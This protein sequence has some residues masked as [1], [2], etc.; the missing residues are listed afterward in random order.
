MSKEHKLSEADNMRS[1][2]DEQLSKTMHYET[3][4]QVFSQQGNSEGVSSVLERVKK[5]NVHINVDAQGIEGKSAL[6]YAVERAI[7]KKSA[8]CDPIIELLLQE[9]AD[10]YVADGAGRSPIE[11]AIGLAKAGDIALLKKFN[12]LF[13]RD[14]GVLSNNKRLN[15]EASGSRPRKK[16]GAETYTLEKEKNGE[17]LVD[18]K[19]AKG[20]IKKHR[21]G[22]SRHLKKLS[23][24]VFDSER[25]TIIVTA[26]GGEKYTLIPKVDG[27][28]THYYIALSDNQ[29]DFDEIMTAAALSDQDKQMIHER[30]GNLGYPKWA[31]ALG[32]MI[33][34]QFLRFQESDK[35]A[36]IDREIDDKIK[37]MYLDKTL[38]EPK[39]YEYQ[40][41]EEIADTR[42]KLDKLK[43]DSNFQGQVDHCLKLWQEWIEKQLPELKEAAKIQLEAFRP[44]LFDDTNTNF[45]ADHRNLMY[46]AGK[47]SIEIITVALDN[48]LLVNF[49]KAR[50]T[51]LFKGEGELLVCA[52]GCT[53]NLAHIADGIKSAG[54]FFPNQLARDFVKRLVEGAARNPDETGRILSNEILW[55]LFHSQTLYKAS[56]VDS[57]VTWEAVRKVIEEEVKL[58]LLE[59]EGTEDQR[60]ENLAIKQ[61]LTSK[62]PELL[63]VVAAAAVL[64]VKE[65]TAKIERIIAEGSSISIEILVK[66]VVRKAVTAVADTAVINM[67]NGNLES[68]IN[69]FVNKLQ[70]A[71]HTSVQAVTQRSISEIRT[72]FQQE[73]IPG[74]QIHGIAYLENKAADYLGLTFLSREDI[75]QEPYDRTI[76]S[77]PIAIGARS[78]R[79]AILNEFFRSILSAITANNVAEFIS[80]K[81]QAE[82]DIHEQTRLKIEKEIVKAEEDGLKD[83]VSRLKDEL[84]AAERRLTLELQNRLDQLGVDKN[85]NSY[86][87]FDVDD[88]DGK[89][90][91]SDYDAAK[92]TIAE[93]L[94]NSG[95]FG[96][97]INK[98]NRLA[99]LDSPFARRNP[100]VLSDDQFLVKFLAKLT[101]P[102]YRIVPSD[103]GLTWVDVPIMGVPERH[104][105]L[106]LLKEE[107]GIEELKQAIEKLE[108]IETLDL[109]IQNR[110]DLTQCLDATDGV[111]LLKPLFSLPFT[112]DSVLFRILSTGETSSSQRLIS[113]IDYFN[114]LTDKQAEYIIRAYPEFLMVSWEEFIG[115]LR[116][117]NKKEFIDELKKANSHSSSRFF[118]ELLRFLAK[119]RKIEEVDNLLEDFSKNRIAFDINAQGLHG[120]TALHYAV[121]NADPF[122]MVELLL[123]KGADPSVL[124]YDNDNKRPF[125]GK[126]EFM[127][128]DRKE[129]TRLAEIQLRVYAKHK[130]IGYI[131]YLLNHFDKKNIN[132]NINAQGLDG[133]TALYYAVENM[134]KKNEAEAPILNL[135][136]EKGADPRADGV[137]DLLKGQKAEWSG[138]LRARLEAAAA[139]KSRRGPL[140]RASEHLSSNGCQ[141]G[142]SGGRSKRAVDC[143]L[144]GDETG[145]EVDFDQFDQSRIDKKQLKEYQEQL[146]DERKEGWEK[147][148]KGTTTLVKAIEIVQHMAQSVSCLVA[149]DQ[150]GD[151][152]SKEMGEIIVLSET[153]STLLRVYPNHIVLV[154]LDSELQNHP[155]KFIANAKSQKLLSEIRSEAVAWNQNHANK[156][157]LE[158]F[159]TITSQ[160][161]QRIE[162][163]SKWVFRLRHQQSLLHTP[164]QYLD[165][166][167]RLDSSLYAGKEK[168]LSPAFKDLVAKK[169]WAALKCLTQAD[170]EA[171]QLTETAERPETRQKIQQIVRQITAVNQANNY[172]QEI[173]EK[174]LPILKERVDLSSQEV[175]ALEECLKIDQLVYASALVENPVLR[176]IL[177]NTPE[178]LLQDQTLLH[179]L[180]RK[181][182]KNLGNE[183]LAKKPLFQVSKQL[184]KQITRNNKRNGK[185]E[186]LVQEAYMAPKVFLAVSARLRLSAIMQDQGLALGISEETQQQ[187]HRGSVRAIQAMLSTHKQHIETQH[188]GDQH[189]ASRSVEALKARIKRLRMESSAISR[190]RLKELETYLNDEEKAEVLARESEAYQREL[191]TIPRSQLLRVKGK[192]SIRVKDTQGRLNTLMSW[193][194]ADIRNPKHYV[195]RTTSQGEFLSLDFRTQEGRVYPITQRLDT[196]KG[197]IHWYLQVNGYQVDLNTIVASLPKKERR[198]VRLHLRKIKQ[199]ITLLAGKQYLEAVGEKALQAEQVLIQERHAL[200]RQ[201]D[202]SKRSEV[203]EILDKLMSDERFDQLLPYDEGITRLEAELKKANIPYDSRK[204]EAA[205]ATGKS[206]GKLGIMRGASLLL[207]SYGLSSSD[208]SIFR[209]ASRLDLLDICVVAGFLDDMNDLREGLRFS[210]K[211]AMRIINNRAISGGVA[212]VLAKDIEDRFN[213]LAEGKGDILDI[214]FITSNSVKLLGMGFSYTSTAI[215]LAARYGIALPAKLASAGAAA[216]LFINMG[217]KF[218]S[219]A[220]FLFSVIDT[221]I[222]TGIEID[223]YVTYI[224]HLEKTFPLSDYEKYEL[225]I[226]NIV[227]L[228]VLTFRSNIF[229]EIRRVFGIKVPIK[230]GEEYTA[231]GSKDYTLA[232]QVRP[233]VDQ[234]KE[235]MAYQLRT[236]SDLAAVVSYADVIQLEY[237]NTVTVEN[238]KLVPKQEP[239]Q[240]GEPGD[241]P[242]R[243]YSYSC[244]YERRYTSFS[245][246]PYLD[247]EEDDGTL[248]RLAERYEKRTKSPPPHYHTTFDGEK[249][250]VLEGYA[251]GRAKHVPVLSRKEYE[252]EGIRMV[253]IPK[254]PVDYSQECDP[255]SPPDAADLTVTYPDKRQ[256]TGRTIVCSELLGGERTC[257]DEF[258]GAKFS[259]NE[260]V[261]YQCAV[262]TKLVKYTEEQEHDEKGFLIDYV[263]NKASSSP[264]ILAVHGR[265]HTATTVMYLSA[266]NRYWAMPSYSAVMKVPARPGIEWWGSEQHDTVFRIEAVSGFS[267]GAVLHPGKQG[268][269]NAIVMIANDMGS[270]RVVLPQQD[271]TDLE[272]FEGRIEGTGRDTTAYTWYISVKGGPVARFISTSQAKQ[273]ITTACSTRYVDT[274]PHATTGKNVI[275]T[276]NSNSCKENDREVRRVNREDEHWRSHKETLLIV[277]PDCI[278]ATIRMQFDSKSSIAEVRKRTVDILRLEEAVDGRQLRIRQTGGSDSGAAYHIERVVRGRT[279]PV[280]TIDNFTQLVFVLH[281]NPS[282]IPGVCGTVFIRKKTWDER[283]EDSLYQLNN[284]SDPTLNSDLVAT[285]KAI[286]CEDPPLY[287]T[288]NNLTH[289]AQTIADN[290]PFGIPLTHVQLDQQDPQTGS[291]HRQVIITGQYSTSVDINF[292]SQEPSAEYAAP[293]IQVSAK[294]F[295]ATVYSLQPLS[296]ELYKRVSA[297]GNQPL[298]ILKHY[299]PSDIIDLTA[300]NVT[301]ITLTKQYP[302]VQSISPYLKIDLQLP[303]HSQLGTPR[304]RA[305]V[306]LQLEDFF[307]DPERQA[308]RFKNKMEV[309]RV[310]TTTLTLEAIDPLKEA[311]E[312]ITRLRSL[313]SLDDENRKP[314]VMMYQ[315]VS[316]RNEENKKPPSPLV[317]EKKRRN[318]PPRELENSNGQPPSVTSAA[319]QSTFFLIDAINTA[320]GMIKAGIDSF[321]SF[322]PSKADDDDDGVTVETEYDEG[323]EYVAD[324]ISDTGKDTLP[325]Q[326]SAERLGQEANKAADFI[327]TPES[328]Q[329]EEGVWS[330][331]GNFFETAY[332]SVLSPYVSQVDG[333]GSLLLLHLLQYY[334]TGKPNPVLAAKGIGIIEDSRLSNVL[335]GVA[336]GEIVTEFEERIRLCAQ[337]AGISYSNI[338]VESTALIQKL[339]KVLIN[340]SIVELSAILKVTIQGSEKFS[341]EHKKKFNAYL[342][343]EIDVIQDL[344]F[345]PA[346]PKSTST[347]SSRRKDSGKKVANDQCLGQKQAAAG[348]ISHLLPKNRFAGTLWNNSNQFFLGNT[349][350][351]SVQPVS[352]RN[353]LNG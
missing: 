236:Y 89:I 246:E 132:Y 232:G 185:I 214:Y 215:K 156:R 196:M 256:I 31:I 176:K 120:R 207:S 110:N 226:D 206:K 47:R 97:D 212:Y 218:L 349:T 82:M 39:Y 195:L 240:K 7:E 38:G 85:Y 307:S 56:L 205:K 166:L 319:T 315:N 2:A 159:I 291:P 213:K 18:T 237:T 50:M 328:T 293:S 96:I 94:L 106:K 290:S 137:M 326:E 123:L 333:N 258:K 281:L 20:K 305:R 136:L 283:T 203:S 114:L 346:V 60:P 9:G 67:P 142:G 324:P 108:T 306:D 1:D 189:T 242:R 225:V 52:D 190:L 330:M 320:K 253:S 117:V 43:A 277:S 233:L 140:K 243:V 126:E 341:E 78:S 65:T 73:T 202:E 128:A 104:L 335:A 45:Y 33:S 209:R 4:L 69:A 245:F 26:A 344:F 63:Q 173:N 244:P 80:M 294:E 338:K 83:E 44:L 230:R 32:P 171:M 8:E 74:N 289:L 162:Q 15:G 144:L 168:K 322:W 183:Y 101:G 66:E 169:T 61:V 340:K 125:D 194:T 111:K 145:I 192:L 298:L 337:S 124:I 177:E 284:I 187:I 310:N 55:L 109:L 79:D 280:V 311:S 161:T 182:R 165:Q 180:H 309:S 285:M 321:S 23:N 262:E 122:H 295:G 46:G 266:P 91:K 77:L 296:V 133:K 317:K 16:R 119:Y 193:R 201:V 72:T 197:K 75:F 267:D 302:D 181:L 343:K 98:G 164:Q 351:T 308:I 250:Y 249:V 19:D 27:P 345:G 179:S 49:L 103:I 221:A 139:A 303:N 222:T 92:L 37:K 12:A 29:I 48:P 5:E 42:K 301:G 331:L 257:E 313:S 121:E 24:Y 204:V 276:R 115:K 71:I 228:R 264:Y 318:R 53:T 14:E 68:D 234:L 118:E 157:S 336:A 30:V 211:G 334:I 352:G 148:K 251:K 155:E 223:A 163:E 154:L 167:V 90:I 261:E 10:P 279:E 135:L 41:N 238:R 248:Y 268:E 21:I 241:W 231:K 146:K 332:S 273:Y 210:G 175:K 239:L 271:D 314:P 348:G 54:N 229:D 278:N 147:E 353:Q 191:L 28:T 327:A 57:A 247:Q 292:N 312:L 22:D 134:V 100:Q 59:V 342:E 170:A 323:E 299:K 127:D 300:L 149:V 76:D 95:Y 259:C 174:L 35:A 158:D 87:I 86:E 208:L 235:T 288:S 143:S 265:Q 70:S 107:G 186:N 220:N 151:P 269:G 329:Q 113:F 58:M 286:T 224:N 116:E 219:K 6:L 81:L 150:L 34:N 13:R 88:D 275:E 51:N 64:Q 287:R 339:S 227:L 188:G 297:T 36:D 11:L 304:H 99:K 255:P 62:N 131:R 252:D 184:N 152:V 325:V 25:S 263:L 17:I 129:T 270:M 350:E 200:L 112:D 198:P 272:Y 260:G 274:G 199:K 93:R 84:T 153:V 40:T 282:W 172:Y 105:F 347:T 102:R 216:K 130:N 141:S 217:T 160:L 178:K 138:P 3:R 316:L 254:K